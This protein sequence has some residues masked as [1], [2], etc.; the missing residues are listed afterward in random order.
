MRQ[1]FY[2]ESIEGEA[3]TQDRES[4]LVKWDNTITIFATSRST[5]VNASSRPPILAKVEIVK[6]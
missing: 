4:E 1:K 3:K 6:E 2:P 5:S